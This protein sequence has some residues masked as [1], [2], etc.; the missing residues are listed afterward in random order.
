MKQYLLTFR[1]FEGGEVTTISYIIRSEM[2]LLEEELVVL[3]NFI[4]TSPD[5]IYDPVDCE[6]IVEIEDT[7]DTK[8]FTLKRKEAIVKEIY[9]ETT[10]NVANVLQIPEEKWTK[11]NEWVCGLAVSLEE[12]QNTM[13]VAGQYEVHQ[14]ELVSEKELPLLIESLKT[15]AGKRELERRLKNDSRNDV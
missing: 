2:N 15:D 14:V 6:I 1:F 13:W 11:L 5:D 4:H 12:L 8:T 3:Y 9:L 10:E 7:K